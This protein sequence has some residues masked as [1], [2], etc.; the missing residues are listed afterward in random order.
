MA[1]MQVPPPP[2]GRTCSFKKEQAWASLESTLQREIVRARRLTPFV[3]YEECD[4]QKTQD[5]PV[6]ISESRERH[7][8]QGKDTGSHFETNE[9]R[10]DRRL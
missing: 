1:M 9:Y 6:L 10:S 2:P 8:L 4:N 3:K 5:Q 7:N